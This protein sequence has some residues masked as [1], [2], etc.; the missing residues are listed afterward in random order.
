MDFRTAFRT[1]KVK[2]SCSVAAGG[3]HLGAPPVFQEAFRLM[4]SGMTVSIGEPYALRKLFFHRNS[5]LRHLLQRILMAF[6]IDPGKGAGEQMYFHAGP[7]DI[8][9]GGAD[10]VFGCDSADIDICSVQKREYFSE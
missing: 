8:L 7:E 1:A 10:A 2:M 3:Q 6:V 4:L 5:F 9:A